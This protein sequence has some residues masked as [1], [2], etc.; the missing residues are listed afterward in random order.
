MGYFFLFKRSI[1][2]IKRRGILSFFKNGINHTINILNSKKIGEL[3]FSHYF[4]KKRNLNRRFIKKNLREFN[5]KNFD[6]YFNYRLNSKLI[7]KNPIVYGFGNGAQIKFEESIAEKYKYAS[8][9]CYDPTTK[10]F[11]NN[12]SG[13]KNI[14]LFSYGIW[15]SDEKIKFLLNKKGGTG[16]AINYYYGSAEKVE[17]YF[18]C[19]KLKT[20]MKM[21]NHDKIDIIKMDIEGIAI[22]VTNNFLDDDILPG[23]IAVEFEFSQKDNLNEDDINKYKIY[24]DQLFKLVNRMKKLNYSCYNNPRTTMPYSSIEII[25]VKNI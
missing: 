6:N 5:D 7:P 1:S 24:E 8:I 4:K 14:K 18:Q 9:Y 22:D 15:T 11:N 16:S 10:E 12:Y 21:N 17:E 3:P 25:F 20:L 19:Y 23:Q 13:P 2:H